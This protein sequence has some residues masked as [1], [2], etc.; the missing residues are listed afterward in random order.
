VGKKCVAGE[1]KELVSVIE[2]Q[3]LFS[4]WEKKDKTEGRKG[5]VRGH[6]KKQREK[7]G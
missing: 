5:R 3:R 1:P 7:K 4:I 2:G 6:L